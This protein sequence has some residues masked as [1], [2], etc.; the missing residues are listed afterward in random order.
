MP[1]P[2]LRHFADTAS[3]WFGLITCTESLLIL[4]NVSRFQHSRHILN[5]R[6]SQSPY[7]TSTSGSCPHILIVLR[8][9]PRRRHS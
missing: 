5:L 6:P 4:W 9:L 1:E 2:H 3:N 7:P 8:A